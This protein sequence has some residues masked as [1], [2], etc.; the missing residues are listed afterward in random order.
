MFDL[1]TKKPEETRVFGEWVAKT[2][3]P[4][5]VLL[6]EGDLGAGKTLLVQSIAACLQVKEQVTSPT[7]GLLNIYDG[8]MPI[9]HF[10]L[11]RLEREEEL[12]EI[13]FFEYSEAEDGLVVI[14]WPDRFPD[15]LPADHVHIKILRGDTDDERRIFVSSQGKRSFCIC[16]ELSQLCRF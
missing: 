7:F 4:G 9:Y 6:L 10:D 12:E 14:E 3:Q 8:K 13:G 15:S 2:I 16:E 5:T 1:I 11:Y